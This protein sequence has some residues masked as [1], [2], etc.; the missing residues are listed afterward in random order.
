L[1]EF[2]SVLRSIALVVQ[3]WRS[4]RVGAF[5]SGRRRQ[6]TVASEICAT[7]WLAIATRTIASRTGQV[8]RKLR[9]S[10]T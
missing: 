3:T 7:P 6:S 4:F 1:I 8:R 9:G 2:Y 5:S 10:L